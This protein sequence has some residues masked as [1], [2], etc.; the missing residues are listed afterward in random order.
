[1]IKVKRKVF[2]G[3]DDCGRNSSSSKEDQAV[4]RLGRASFVFNLSAMMVD[5]DADFPEQLKE[6]LKIPNLLACVV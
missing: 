3:I 1:M 5:T 4:T 2:A 6:L